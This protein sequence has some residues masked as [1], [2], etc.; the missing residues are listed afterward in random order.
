MGPTSNSEERRCDQRGMTRNNPPSNNDTSH[1][2]LQNNTD[3]SCV[4]PSQTPVEHVYLVS[5]TAPICTKS[6]II[7]HVCSHNGT[8]CNRGYHLRCRNLTAVDKKISISGFSLVATFLGLTPTLEAINSPT[9]F[10]PNVVFSLAPLETYRCLY[11]HRSLLPH[12][13]IFSLTYLVT[14]CVH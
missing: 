9:C 12:L 13:N 2:C 10:D 4:V 7:V 11:P 3:W 6:A 14:L 1:A 5:E 8:Y